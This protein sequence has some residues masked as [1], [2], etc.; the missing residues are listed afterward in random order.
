MKVKK[1]KAQENKG[2][3]NTVDFKTLKS[4]TWNSKRRFEI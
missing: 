4:I 1:E 2:R 3:T